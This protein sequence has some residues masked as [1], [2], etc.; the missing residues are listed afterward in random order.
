MIGNGCAS[1]GDA[2]DAPR[3]GRAWAPRRLATR[4]VASG[5]VALMAA[6]VVAG[7]GSGDVQLF[8]GPDDTPQSIVLTVSALGQDAAALSWTAGARGLVYRVDRNGVPGATTAA[9]QTTAS[10]LKP[11]ERYCW[12]ILGYS[13][14]GWQARSNEACLG[15]EP[16]T[17]DWRFERVAAGRWP[18]VAVDAGGAPQVCFAAAAGAGVSWIAVGPGR[19]PQQVDA[20]G[21][22]SCSIA[23][24]AD[25]TVHLAYLSRFGLRHAVRE[26]GRWQASTV[27]AQALAGA[28]RAD[29]PAL[30]LATDGT[31]RIAYRRTSVTGVVQL[32][33]ASRRG[34]GWSVDPLPLDG[35]VGPRSLTVDASGTARL[36]TVDGLGQSMAAWE[37]TPEGWRL[38][39]AESL[40]PNRGDGPPLVL[41]PKGAMR[42]AGWHRAAPTTTAPVTLR[43]VEQT[44]SGWRTETLATV[45]DVG[46]RVAIALAGNG[47]ARVA[48]V[49]ASGAVRLYARGASGWI[50]ETLEGQVGRAAAIDLAVGADGQLRLAFDRLDALE[51]WLASRRP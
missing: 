49:D 5:R 47:V 43:W 31:P 28:D 51:V 30:A 44:T 6:L 33:V 45:P 46:T 29:G 16:D 36:A 4:P 26:S 19:E 48:A 2:A 35:R 10:G 40:A 3:R 9:L 20:D 37:R 21:A 42:F 50:A 13:G 32:A 41:D 39:H 7:C 22:G 15:T 24:A 17:S 25:G 27:D 14:W 11:G 23:I 12:R 1:D 18:A 8:G 34:P 38:G